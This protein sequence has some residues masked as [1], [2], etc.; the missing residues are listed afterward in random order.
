MVSTVYRKGIGRAPQFY[1][2]TLWHG[3]AEYGDS[4]RRTDYQ[5]DLGVVPV[6]QA[7]HDFL[8][9]QL[10]P[11]DLGDLAQPVPQHLSALSGESEILGVL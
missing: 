10:R 9:A 4:G 11:D 8:C 6:S 7:E 5:P 3:P 2:R 1:G